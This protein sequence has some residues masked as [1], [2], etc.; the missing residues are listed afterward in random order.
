MQS[1]LPRYR[2][3]IEYDGAPF[4]GW[5]RQPGA[6]TVESALTDALTVVL[7][8]PV[9]IVGSGRTDAGVHATG[10]VAHLD[11]DRE[12]D[13]ELL[14]RAANGLLAHRHGGSV[15]VLAAE[16]TTDDFHARYDAR[17]RLY[18]YRASGEPRALDRHL[19]WIVAPTPDWE[20]MNEEAQHLLGR[21]DFNSFCITQSGTRN[22]V[23]SI[24][25]ARWRPE[26][27]AGDWRFEIAADRFLHG[28]VRAIVGTLMQVGR[29]RRQP[30]T[31]AQVLEQRDR[32]A[33]GPAA[34]AHGLVLAA[35]TYGEDP[36]RDTP[37]APQE[38][39]DGQS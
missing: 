25:Q 36:A 2:L 31:L 12:A 15:V 26:E 32:R 28:M 27:R 7:R 29:G 38:P 14:A 39:S 8:Q 22:R 35:V 18:Y 1:S 9:S 4:S 24:E 6:T 30:G 3:L 17:R 21:H 11:L 16:R 34:P 23:C 37:L 10:Q 13:P 20:L 5:Q 19:R 33:A